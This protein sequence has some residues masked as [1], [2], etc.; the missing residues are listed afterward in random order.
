LIIFLRAKLS[1]PNIIHLCWCNW[2][3]FWRKNKAGISLSLSC[4]CTNMFRLTGNLQPKRNRPTW[5]SSFLITHPIHQI[6]PRR[7]ITCSLDWKNN[8]KLAIYRPTQ[9]SLLPRRPGWT[10][11]FLN[12]LFEWLAKERATG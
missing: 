12:F 3:K 5:A 7:T 11:N 1:T 6:W 10:D 8:W 4:S 9:T 2:R